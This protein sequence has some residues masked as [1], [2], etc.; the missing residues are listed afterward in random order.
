[1]KNRIEPIGVKFCLLPGNHDRWTPYR[2]GHDS[3]VLS[4]GYDPGGTDFHSVFSSYWGP[5]DVSTFTIPKDN[6]SVTV[7]TADFSLRFASDAETWKFV[8]KHGQGRVYED[9]L[10]A[11]E[12][13]TLDAMNSSEMTTAVLWAVHFPPFC[14]DIGSDMRLIDQRKLLEKADELG[15]RIILAGHSHVA[16]PYSALPYETDVFCAGTLTEY[17]HSKNQFYIISFED[18]GG[19]Y[20]VQLEN[21]EYDRLRRRFIRR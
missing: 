3:A 4:F 7:I 1:M 20:R 16:N 10:T 19:N 9:I 21:Y 13:A 2:K 5:E 8:N 6:L 18:L 15:V 14:P 17:N 11:L 12:S